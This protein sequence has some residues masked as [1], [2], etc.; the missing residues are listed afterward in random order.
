MYHDCPGFI[1][2]TDRSERK[3]AAAATQQLRQSCTPDSGA[4][5]SLDSGQPRDSFS[6]GR[7]L[8]GHAERRCLFVCLCVRACVFFRAFLDMAGGLAGDSETAGNLED[9]EGALRWRGGG[10]MGKTCVFL[11]V[12][13]C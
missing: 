1:A 5:F 11:W 12:S 2:Q 7:I 13:A 4:L 10:Q 6:S 8:R 9:M 3:Y